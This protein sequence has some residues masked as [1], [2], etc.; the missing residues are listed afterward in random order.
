MKVEVY[1]WP[2]PAHE[3]ERLTV[4]FELFA[5]PSLALLRDCLYLLRV[6]ML[7]MHTDTVSSTGSDGAASV[8]VCG[9]GTWL[10]PRNLCTAK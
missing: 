7:D 3:D 9:I 6:D 10:R 5:P 2:L 4:V 8:A 1:E